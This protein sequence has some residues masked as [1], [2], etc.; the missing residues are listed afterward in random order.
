MVVRIV[1][2]DHYARS[3]A[4]SCLPTRSREAAHHKG[5]L[6]RIHDWSSSLR[7]ARSIPAPRHH[8][9]VIQNGVGCA[10]RQEAPLPRRDGVN[11]PR[12]IHDLPERPAPP[13]LPT[14]EE[15]AQQPSGIEE[16]RPEA[17][18]ARRPPK[19][20]RR[21]GAA[22]APFASASRY[23]SRADRTTALAVTPDDSHSRSSA[24]SVTS[25]NRTDTDFAM[26]FI[27]HS[28]W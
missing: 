24:A 19:R 23:R 15:G 22:S 8:V 14:D 12:R 2:S 1:R 11:D 5:R 10:A 20:R 6:F 17:H 27:I 25:G 9:P 7:G 21:A 18:R 28:P 3:R 16:P 4:S 13:M 26:C